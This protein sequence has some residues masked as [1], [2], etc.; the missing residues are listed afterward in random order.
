MFSFFGQ[1]G[2]EVVKLLG[3]KSAPECSPLYMILF[4]SLIGLVVLF[5]ILKHLLKY[6]IKKFKKQ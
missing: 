6:G 1:L 3:V 5:F 2:I 4:Y